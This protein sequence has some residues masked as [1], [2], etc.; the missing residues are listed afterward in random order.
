MHCRAWPQSCES[1]RT[2]TRLNYEESLQRL[3]NASRAWRK[4]MAKQS[5][6]L[7]FTQHLTADQWRWL[8]STRI[9]MRS[10]TFTNKIHKG[11]IE[12]SAYNH[13]LGN[14]ELRASRTT[15]QVCFLYMDPAIPHAH[16]AI[17]DSAEFFCI[18][19]GDPTYF[20]LGD[21]TLYPRP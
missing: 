4:I 11:S 15:L 3:I 8:S 10:V 18:S 9:T 17:A 7:I 1:G 12:V 16:S 13:L 2:Q 19:C 21:C 5:I 20:E 6:D 14:S